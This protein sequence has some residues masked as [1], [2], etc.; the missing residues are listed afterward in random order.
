VAE[1]ITSLIVTSLD[2][3]VTKTVTIDVQPVSLSSFALSGAPLNLTTNGLPGTVTANTFRGSDEQPFTGDVNVDWA[4]TAGT[5]NPSGVQRYGTTYTVTPGSSAA[6][7]TIT[8][9]AGG[10]TAVPFTVTITAWTG[11]TISSA[12]KDYNIPPTTNNS[13]GTDGSMAKNWASAANDAGSGNYWSSYLSNGIAPSSGG[14]NLMVSNKVYSL[15]HEVSSPN[16]SGNNQTAAVSLG[17]LADGISWADAVKKCVDL[18]EGGF[19]DWYLPNSMELDVLFTEGFLGYST[20]GAATT[21]LYWSS[22]ENS[23]VNAQYRYF[24]GAAAYPGFNY[25]HGAWSANIKGISRCVR[26]TD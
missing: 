6:T 19:D 3:N 12:A 14:T 4:V 15:A 7:W 5:E 9:S 8:P 21:V 23:A 25:K 17:A 1:G 2:N 16:P 24:V 26:R 22:T 18:T 10:F 11:S 20:L 13:A